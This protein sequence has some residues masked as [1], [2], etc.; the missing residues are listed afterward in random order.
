MAA[1]IKTEAKLAQNIVKLL[2]GD[3]E[4][5]VIEDCSNSK[6]TSIFSGPTSVEQRS[7]FFKDGKVGG[8]VNIFLVHNKGQWSLIDAG[9][10]KVLLPSLATIGVKVEDIST[11][12]ITHMHPDHIQGLFIGNTAT[13][14]KAR[15]F[16]SENEKALWIPG[17]RQTDANK[18]AE[19]YGTRLETL[20]YGAE[21]APGI[22]SVNLE[23][24]TAGHTG[25]EIGSGVNR[26]LI[27]GDL[28]HHTTLQFFCPEEC[29]SYDADRPTLPTNS[30]DAIANI[31]PNNLAMTT[32]NSRN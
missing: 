27:V 1:A 13:F 2:V 4:V 12:L 8:S 25:Y 30:P 16:V 11:I 20:K 18:V 15:V 6:E 22:I 14:P 10:G 32:L 28:I 29:A 26:L 17:N 9:Y 24:H 19:I 5:Y 31:H 7:I 23:G 3:A 21:V